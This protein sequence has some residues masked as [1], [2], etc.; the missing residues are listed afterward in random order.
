MRTSYAI[1]SIGEKVINLL[2]SKNED[3][4]DSATEGESNIS[5]QI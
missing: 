5:Q 2:L 3:Y 1:K 4:G